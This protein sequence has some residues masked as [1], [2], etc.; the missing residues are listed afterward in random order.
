MMRIHI[1]QHVPFEGPGYIAHWAQ[2]HGYSLTFSHLYAGDPLPSVAD[3]E[4]LVIMG[5]PMGVGD[6]SRYAWLSAEK[7][8]IRDFVPTKK[9]ILGICL[10]AQLVAEALGGCVEPHLHHEIGWFPI[11][12]TPAG[13]QMP[14]TQAWPD[15]LQV[16]HWHGDRFTVPEGA[17]HLIRSAACEQQGFCYG[18]HVLGLQ[19]HLEMTP[20]IVLSLCSETF[21]NP[22]IAPPSGPW[23]QDQATLRTVATSTYARMHAA[24]ATTLATL[25]ASA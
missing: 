16:L 17:T 23:I 18:D 10:G 21:A 12:R 13:Q 14:F 8:L 19:C 2:Q 1:I 20:E 24:L 3:I 4:R 11:Q 22:A 25:F 6:E 9:P 7:A 15:G 5:G